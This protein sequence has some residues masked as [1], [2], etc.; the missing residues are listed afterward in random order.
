MTRFLVNRSRADLNSD[1]LFRRAL[2]DAIQEIGEAAARTTLTGRQCA[3]GVPWGKIV[4]MRQFLVHVYWGVDF[5]RL[6][7]TATIDVPEL[8]PQL[9]DAARH[10]PDP[11]PSP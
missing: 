8:L 6:W 9:E 4:Q 10:W 5:D 11:P 1:E 7:D 3:P 2:M